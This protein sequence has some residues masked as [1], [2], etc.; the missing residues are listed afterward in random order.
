MN[1]TWGIVVAGG[2]GDRFGGPKQFELL[3]GEPLW[4]WARRSLI[5]GGVHD[6]VIVADFDGAAPPGDRRR[7]S[8]ESGLARVPTG[9]DFVLVHDAARPL[10]TPDLVRRVIARLE[11]GDVAGVVP[12]TP[13]HDATKRVDGE[14]V[15][16]AV[17]RDDLVTVQ[18]PQGFAAA[19]LREAHQRIG[20]DAAD[21]AEMVAEIGGAVVTVPG[22][23]TN[24]K[25]TVPSDLRLVEAIH[26]G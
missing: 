22:E 20:G 9:V 6:V 15:V 13:I 23:V 1:E 4:E 17:T 11:I 2:R 19:Q 5:D 12:A 3:G 14:R 18:T 16:A 10:A 24:L 25:V 21:D 8:V 7:D 26:A